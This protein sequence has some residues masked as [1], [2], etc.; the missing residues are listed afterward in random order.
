[1][2][3]KKKEVTVK[4]I[5]PTQIDELGDIKQSIKKLKK[6]EKKL[7]DEI[8]PNMA[9]HEIIET[10]KYKAELEVKDLRQLDWP[11]VIKKIGQKKFNELARITLEDLGKVIGK[12]E[13]DA[14]TLGYEKQRSLSVDPI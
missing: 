14:L 9:D 12:D 1:M 2:A 5:H 4:Q 3:A 8:K 10:A 7:V 11:A 13:I 6:D